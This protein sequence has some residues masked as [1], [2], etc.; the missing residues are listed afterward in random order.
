M[1]ID[2]EARGPPMTL[3]NAAA[4]QVRLSC[5]ARRASIRPSPT[6]PRWLPGTTPKRR[7]S[8][9]AS[10]WSAPGRQVD[11]AVTGTARR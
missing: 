9:G 2:R 8:I 3:G 10:G 4:A 7:R 11:M 5:G 6:P 1:A